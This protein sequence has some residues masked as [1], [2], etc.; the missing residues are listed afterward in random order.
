MAR[1][2]T[3]GALCWLLAGYMP[4]A[5][6]K[7]AGPAPAGAPPSRPFLRL[8]SGGHT[9]IIKRIAVDAAGR[10]L[11]SASDDK[12]ARVWDAASGA[13]LQTLRPP[14]GEGNEGKLYAVALSP[15]GSTVALGGWTGYGWDGTN[16]IYLFDRADG[17]LVRRLAGLPNVIHDLAFS[18]DGRYLAAAL[19]GANG[20]RVYRS[21][22]WQEAFR[23]SDYGAASYSLDFAADGRLLASS[24]DGYLRLYDGDFRL[25]AQRAAP[26]GKQPLFAR[27]APDGDR[28]AAG[29][30]DS[31]AVNL[32]AGRDLAFLSAPDTAQAA[33][34]NLGS[35]AWSAD[36]GRLLAGG[37]YIESGKFPLLAWNAAGT[38]RP[39]AWPVSTNTLMDLRPLPGGRLAFAAADPLLGVLDD[40][41]RPLWRRGGGILDFRGRWSDFR[42]SAD[43]GVVE[44][45]FNT[46]NA[47]GRLQRHRARFDLKR[48]GLV[49]EPT[50]LAGLAAPNTQGEPRTDWLDTTSPKV[51]GQV[52]TLEVNETAFSLALAPAGTGFL[53]GTEWLLRYYDAPGRLRW[54]SAVPGTAWAVNLSGD[55]RYAVAAFGDGSIRWYESQGGKEVLALFVHP[56][57]LNPA[58]PRWIA[59]TPE[60]FYDAAPGAEALI[61]YHL[62]QGAGQ[63]G[64]FVAAAQLRERFYRPSLIARRLSA[65]GDALL[66]EALRQLGDVGQALAEGAPP[67]VELLGSPKEIAPGEFELSLRVPP[68]T[69]LR[70][71][72]DGKDELQGRDAGLPGIGRDVVSRRFRLPEGEHRLEITAGNARGVASEPLQVELAVRPRSA[73]PALRVLAVGIQDYRDHALAQGVKFAA[74]DAAGIAA[75][76]QSQGAKL[77]SRVAVHTL[78]DGEA[79]G[80][81]IRQAMAEAAAQT[82]PDDVFVLYLAGHGLAEDDEY[83]FVPWDARYTNR[84]ELLQHSLNEA[85]LR[86]M[87]AAIPAHKTLVMLDSCDSG[88]FI[89]HQGRGPLGEKSAIDRLA[90][91]SGRAILAAASD[92]NMAL[93]GENGHGAFTYALL[94]GLSGKANRDNSDSIDVGELADY[95]Q[96]RLPE[97][98]KQKWGYEQFPLHELNGA[99]FPV[100]PKP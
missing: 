71:R 62:N 88:A 16:S 52:L 74:A 39:Q 43:A 26:G 6:A 29:F 46:W 72:L 87:L 20:I 24:L 33:N 7:D 70:Y 66:A 37:R 14:L 63:A 5:M 58:T 32:L 86:D 94:E 2:H 13:L 73:Q 75:R 27:F 64:R 99:S 79:S 47:D 53:L 98:T 82:G 95:V 50:P 25:L 21:D 23:D 65:E 57:S 11:V 77:Y 41:G 93:E 44:F 15:D 36:G 31:T 48:P 96:D 8:E 59:W 68:G 30:A 9:A 61:G 34:S 55:A 83:H 89:T 18:R 81:A 54:Q 19:G 100:L 28:V 35:V 22:T 40:T 92:K 51:R 91:L 78:R 3:I 42:L 60:G 67:P 97:L 1:W 69:E 4:S 10:Y 85:S 45:G 12:T 38:G 17:R 56:D 90:R 80:A 84:D 76:F 49:L